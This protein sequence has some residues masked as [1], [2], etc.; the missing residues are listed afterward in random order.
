VNNLMRG[1]IGYGECDVVFGDLA[2]IVGFGAGVRSNE[3]C[4]HRHVTGFERL[5]DNTAC[6][7]E[8]AMG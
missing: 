6:F 5:H 8:L 7:V 4:D 1:A 2:R 3:P